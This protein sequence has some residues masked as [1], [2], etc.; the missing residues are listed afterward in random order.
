[1]RKRWERDMKEMNKM[2]KRQ[3]KE[4]R[5]NHGYPADK[6]TEEGVAG[7]CRE[8]KEASISSPTSGILAAT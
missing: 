5:S 1:M 2:R 3:E 4:W 6:A 7:C 8:A